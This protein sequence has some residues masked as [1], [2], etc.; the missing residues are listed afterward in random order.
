[1]FRRLYVWGENPQW[2]TLWAGVTEAVLLQ[3]S[4]AK[5]IPRCI[6]ALILFSGFG[7]GRKSR[8]F[9]DWGDT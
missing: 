9:S 8:R 4:G 6:G 3:V 7:C 1:M 5:S 2:A